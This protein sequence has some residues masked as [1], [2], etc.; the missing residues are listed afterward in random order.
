VFADQKHIAA[1]SGILYGNGFT[2]RL[3]E[4]IRVQ[5]HE[6]FRKI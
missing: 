6:E 4:K 5:Q 3:R 2:V 1:P